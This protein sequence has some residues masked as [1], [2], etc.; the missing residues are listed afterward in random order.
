[1]LV[2][3]DSNVMNICNDNNDDSSSCRR[4]GGR[5]GVQ[6]EPWSMEACEERKHKYS[7]EEALI[8]MWINE[9]II[10]G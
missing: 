10:E 9:V 5:N 6:I 3:D 7:G 4:A 2:Y 1:M 8:V